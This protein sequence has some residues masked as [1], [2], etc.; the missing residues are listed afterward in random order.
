MNKF[1]L[2]YQV[3]HSHL[4]EQDNRNQQLDFKAS[5]VIALSAT[6]MGFAALTVT[7][8]ASWSIWLALSM[9]IDFAVAAGASIPILWTKDFD[10]SPDLPFLSQQLAS[11]DDD[12]LARFDDDGLT[13]W[14]AK[15][16][17]ISVKINDRV[18]DNKADWLEWALAG[19]I[20]EAVLLGLLVI[21][22]NL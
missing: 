14:T 13:L 3:A 12:G 15:E 6:L 9:L 1:D 22:T 5:G 19:L 2:Y 17:S 10:R 21:S 18:L 20:A 8:W 11:S 7:G 4:V 16:F